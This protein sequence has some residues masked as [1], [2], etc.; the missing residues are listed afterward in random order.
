MSVSSPGENVDLFTSADVGHARKLVADGRAEVMA[1]FAR[2]TLCLLG[3]AQPGLTS[4]TVL[5][6]LLTPG[7][8]IGI[9]PPKIDPLGDYTMKLFEVADGLQPGSRASLQARS[10]IIDNPPGSPPPK[11]GDNDVDALQDGRIDV[12]IV[13]CSGRAR[14][15]RL[16]PNAAMVSFP[17]QLQVGPEYA[18]AVMKNAQPMALLL[19]LTILSPAGQETLA[20][21]GFRTVTLPSD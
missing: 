12:D 8:R 20:K 9:S 11:S 19:A 21:Y 16:M 15:A 14:Y 6:H 5:Q 2:N 10:I 1:V 3:Q 7:L 18:L 4:G 13:Y 17:Q